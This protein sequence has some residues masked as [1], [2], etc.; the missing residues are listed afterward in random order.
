MDAIL[1]EIKGDFNRQNSLDLTSFEPKNVVLDQILVLASSIIDILITSINNSSSKKRI[2]LLLRKF[3]QERYWKSKLYDAKVK[4]S[5]FEFFS[6]YNYYYMRFYIERVQ[7]GLPILKKYFYDDTYLQLRQPESPTNRVSASRSRNNEQS[8]T[9]KIK[10]NNYNWEGSRSNNP[11]GVKPGDTTRLRALPQAFILN[12]NMYKA[13]G[14][15]NKSTFDISD[16]LDQNFVKVDSNTKRISSKL[17]K[18]I[19]NNLEAEYMPF[20]F[21]DLRTNEIIS[22]HAFIESISDSFSPEYNSSSGFGRI[23]DVKSYVKTTRNINL[24]F[25]LAATS[26]SDHDL[27][28]WQINKI[29]AMVYPQ[30]SGG[31]KNESGEFTYP[32]TQVPTSSP[33][34]RLRVGDVIKSNYSRTNLGR[35]HGVEKSYSNILSDD[36]L[37]K[38]LKKEDFQV[39]SPDDDL[40]ESL[41]ELE[42]QIKEN[43]ETIKNTNVDDALKEKPKTENK[44]LAKQYNELVNNIDASS[45]RNRYLRPGLYKTTNM[46]LGLGGLLDAAGIDFDL[47]PSSVRIDTEVKIIKIEKVN[48]TNEYV[49]VKIKSP[50]DPS[51]EIAL[52][53]D[54]S[55]VIEVNP[56]QLYKKQQASGYAI[57]ANNLIKVPNQDKER[58]DSISN[59]HNQFKKI[60]SP[61]S[62]SQDNNPITKSYESGMSRG[63]AGFILIRNFY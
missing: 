26:P 43:N 6:D 62:G 27:M 11:I 49:K 29:V 34:I 55:K 19:E 17:V 30:W 10:G 57:E 8:I 61:A 48:I 37:V 36:E 16:D 20:Y 3:Y 4:Q 32:F 41:S 50:F 60:M 53:V 46:S 24:T 21:H 13:I 31:N 59:T 22:F 47:N 44:F 38:G 42:K 28:W 15:N 58:S 54:A 25:V 12:A 51:K 1:Q 45:I 14:M 35:I 23:D 2:K 33:L 40:K 39:F 63:L 7:V 56:K 9:S 5:P 52:A 18:E